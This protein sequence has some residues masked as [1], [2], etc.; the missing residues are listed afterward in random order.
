MRY[1]ITPISVKSFKAY[2]I[3]I[4]VLSSLQIMSIIYG[5]KFF[6]ANYVSSVLMN[7]AK[8]IAKGY[9]LML[10][11]IIVHFTS[12][13]I[14]STCTLIALPYNGYT[15]HDTV[16][17]IM[18]TLIARAVACLLIAPIAVLTVYFIQRFVEKIIIFND[19]SNCWNIFQLNINDDETVVFDYKEW[20]KI[21]AKTRKQMDINS[22]LKNY[23]HKHST[24]KIKIF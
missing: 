22:I 3:I 20:R 5:R 8:Y 21:P 2:P 16:N 13:I 17:I 10:R 9:W 15:L 19:K 4:A 18:E 23:H 24:I 14:L 11:M 12:E 7:Y 6:T 1:V